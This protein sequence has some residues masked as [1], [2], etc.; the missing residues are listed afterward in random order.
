MNRVCLNLSLNYL[1]V[2][3]KNNVKEGQSPIEI[4]NTLLY[5]WLNDVL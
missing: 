4:C 2:L 5:N 3:Y 1:F